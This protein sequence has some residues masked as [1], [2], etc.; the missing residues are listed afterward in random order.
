M[1]DR[2]NIVK[3]LEICASGYC[4]GC[5]YYKPGGLNLGCWNGLMI[6]AAKL[7]KEQELHTLVEEIKWCLEKWNEKHPQKG[8]KM[9]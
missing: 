5:T 2:K 6:D 4:E 3:N 8:G 1:N 7:L 9:E